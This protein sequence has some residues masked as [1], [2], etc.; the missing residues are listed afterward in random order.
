MKK[1]LRTYYE[2][3]KKEELVE[4]RH[5]GLE[6][7]QAYTD[8]S[9]LN[10]SAREKALELAMEP[11]KKQ[12]KKARHIKEVIGIA[13]CIAVIVIIAV[14]AFLINHKL[15]ET[16]AIEEEEAAIKPEGAAVVSELYVYG[17]YLNM[18][19]TLPDIMKTYEVWLEGEKPALDL[20]LYSEDDSYISIPLEVDG[21][22]FRLSKSLNRGLRLDDVPQG[23]YLM[24]IRVG[25]EKDIAEPTTPE[26]EET[27]EAVET[28]STVFRIQKKKIE[29]TVDYAGLQ[30]AEA[31][32]TNPIYDLEGNYVARKSSYK[33][34]TLQNES[35]YPET[36]Y[37]TMTSVGNTV[38]LND[39]SSTWTESATDVTS[40]AAGTEETETE[41]TTSSPRHFMTLGMSVAANTDTEVYDV[42][43]DPGRG[44]TDKGF[45]SQTGE[46]EKSMNLELALKIKSILE[47]SGMK[48]ALTRLKDEDVP[49]YGGRGR[50]A[51]AMK[52]H[53]KYMISL[54]MNSNGNGGIEIYCAMDNDYTL[55]EAMAEDVQN[56]TDI[57]DGV[58]G[59]Y[60]VASNT[61]AR[62][63]TEDE[64]NETIQENIEK[65]L[66]PYAP[67]TKSSYY[68]MIRETGGYAT[69][70]YMD[71][72][73]PKVDYN[74]YAKTNVGQEGYLIYAGYID[75]PEDNKIL[76]NNMDGFAQGIAGPILDFT[77]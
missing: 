58:S 47:G 22:E 19:G 66:K 3:K 4:K 50:V 75:Q 34:F 35:G 33:Y 76:Q 26:S 41:E 39:K 67:S 1:N 52:T 32:D 10:R 68:Y 63:F 43:I 36:T 56:R 17:Q 15:R 46:Y 29:E 25:A 77:D 14:A 54:R 57:K 60:S 27:T 74:P 49:V 42:V 45:Q 44:G 38:V 2:K 70:A 48:V 13:A 72:R 12:E 64:V 51:L 8:A 61:Y 30:E 28:E 21:M 37:Y 65:G 18:S 59:I 7:S 62:N 6:Y 71:D 53:A 55:A 9:L 23:E 73:N 5:G 31:S 24:L 16:K 11:E 69:G 20:V 40:E